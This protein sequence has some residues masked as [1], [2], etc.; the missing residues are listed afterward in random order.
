KSG[1]VKAVPSDFLEAVKIVTAGGTCLQFTHETP[2]VTIFTASRK[3]LGTAFTSPLLV[4]KAGANPCFRSFSDNWPS[5]PR[6]V[7]DDST[8]GRF[9]STFGFPSRCLEI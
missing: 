9:P 1:E 6:K 5:T 4:R 2:A 7:T 8:G 3:S